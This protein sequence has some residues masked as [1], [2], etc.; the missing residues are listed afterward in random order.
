MEAADVLADD[1]VEARA[2]PAAITSP[3]WKL[4]RRRG[5]ARRKCVP[6]ALL[7]CTTIFFATMSSGFMKYC[8]RDQNNNT[9][10]QADGNWNRKWRKNRKT[11]HARGYFDSD[12]CLLDN[13]SRQGGLVGGSGSSADP[14]SD[15]AAGG[16]GWHGARRR[17]VGGREGGR[18]WSVDGAVVSTGAECTG[19]NG[20]GKRN[21]GHN[22]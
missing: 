11:E 3:G 7:L 6:C 17:G 14:G 8:L 16:A 15:A 2:E 13:R 21:Q 1:R 10:E 12:Y 4:T 9:I 22:G 19:L 18:R 20:G 5:P